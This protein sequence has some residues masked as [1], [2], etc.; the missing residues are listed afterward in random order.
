MAAF[1]GLRGLQ[2][3][4]VWGWGGSREQSGHAALQGT[5]ASGGL[6]RPLS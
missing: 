3:D 4:G 2:R 6:S 5:C 1:L